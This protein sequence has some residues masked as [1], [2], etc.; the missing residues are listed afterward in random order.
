[1]AVAACCEMK[2]APDLRGPESVEQTPT[3]TTTCISARTG[4]L[5]AT[6][7]SSAL[8]GSTTMRGWHP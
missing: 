7:A 8:P 1:M 3:T 2:L 6:R 5:F 4:V